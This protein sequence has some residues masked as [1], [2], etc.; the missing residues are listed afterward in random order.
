[1]RNKSLT[2]PK[3]NASFHNASMTQNAYDKTPGAAS[4][5]NAMSATSRC[6]PRS[7][8]SARLAKDVPTSLNNVAYAWVRTKV[9]LKLLGPRRARPE[10]L[11]PCT[12]GSSVAY[13]SSLL[14]TFSSTTSTTTSTGISFFLPTV[15]TPTEP[16]H[17]R[18]FLTAAAAAVEVDRA[19][20]GSDAV[21]GALFSC[22]PRLGSG[23]STSDDSVVAPASAGG[24]SAASACC[25]SSGASFSG[26]AATTRCHARASSSA[27]AMAAASAAA[28]RRASSL[29]ARRAAASAA[30][31]TRTGVGTGPRYAGDSGPY[32][33][34]DS[35]TS[36][37]TSVIPSVVR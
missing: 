34:I 32:S 19:V 1:M 36:Q 15:P 37:Y 31:T 24:A 18:G 5:K 8:A 14:I 16:F 3:P 21:G 29:A 25:G 23:G 30:F 17:A 28:R 35:M 6:K 27:A 22:A 7:M 20:A 12:L 33:W 10:N 2:V 4:H 11:A 26:A 9:R 13:R